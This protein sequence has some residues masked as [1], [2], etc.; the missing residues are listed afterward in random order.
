[1]SVTTYVPVFLRTS[2]VRRVVVSGIEADACA[3]LLALCAALQNVTVQR[4]VVVIDKLPTAAVLQATLR[5]T[6]MPRVVS[7]GTH[8]GRFHADE[9]FACALAVAVQA[10]G[11]L[12]VLVV[13]T[14]DPDQLRQC[15]MVFDVGGVY[16]AAARRFDHH[17]PEFTERYVADADL[18]FKT[19]PMASAGLAWKAFGPALLES[20]GLGATP[21]LLLSAYSS[22]IEGI[23]AKDN[24]FWVCSGKPNYQT[25]HLSGLVGALNR[26]WYARSA[27]AAVMA[28]M[29]PSPTQNERFSTAM[30]IAIEPLY[31]WIDA[32]C[33]KQAMAKPIV[34]AALALA[35]C[36]GDR[37]LMLNRFCSWPRVLQEL[38]ADANQ[39]Y[40]A[41]VQLAV[42]P[43]EKRG[44][45]VQ[46][47]PLDV[48][49]RSAGS[50]RR[51]P[52]AWAGL[53]GAALDAV[54]AGAGVPRGCIFCHKGLFICGHDTLAG[55]M[56]MAAAAISTE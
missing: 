5:A 33:K 56:A 14:R 17:Q 35:R 12:L 13:R 32:R 55:A 15:D 4:R 16:D 11:P 54:V 21:A 7:I 48:D 26:P 36:R 29:A 46:T 25:V 50:R 51:L 1:M 53:N 3:E 39:S 27:A 8:N 44:F 41:R 40:E 38:E 31:A 24:G 9:A 19:T 52:A 2:A 10:P 37:T 20:M 6:G 23:D 45:R 42:F 49:D 47:I 28:G 34:A 43:D 18:P 22:C 30:R